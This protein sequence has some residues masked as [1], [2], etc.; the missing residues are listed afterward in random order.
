LTG[1]SVLRVRGYAEAE[2][3]TTF[4]TLDDEPGP[5]AAAAG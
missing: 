3:R 1:N 2:P 5:A 4:E